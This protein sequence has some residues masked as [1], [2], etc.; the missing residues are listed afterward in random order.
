MLFYF[1][2]Y[3]DFPAITSLAI[4]CIL[5]IVASPIVVPYLVFG[6]LTKI[7]RIFKILRECYK[8]ELDVFNF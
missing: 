8:T 2:D 7:E 6:N 3:S 1:S 4:V 5:I